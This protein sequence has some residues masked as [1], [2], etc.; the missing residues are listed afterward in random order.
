M[1]L[2]FIRTIRE[3]VPLG[4]GAFIAVVALVFALAGA[5]VGWVVDRVYQDAQREAKSGRL[6]PEQLAAQRAA[7]R[8]LR[9]QIGDLIQRGRIL[10]ANVTS[11]SQGLMPEPEKRVGELVVGAM[12]WHL[13]VIRFIERNV[14]HADAMRV[15]IPPPSREYPAGLVKNFTAPD[16]TSGGWDLR[17]TWDFLEGDLAS[18]DR[19]LDRFPEL[20]D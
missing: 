14:S 17:S 5:G 9:N 15:S 10:Q 11:V 8:H 12:Q 20:A 1:P 18:L 2:D 19:T 6:S 4:S 3:V 7:R 13:E 16:G